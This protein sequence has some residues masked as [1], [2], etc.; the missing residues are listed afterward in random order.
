MKEQNHDKKSFPV[1]PAVFAGLLLAVSAVYAGGFLYYQSHFLPGTQI[2]GI[3]VSGMT[4]EELGEQIRDYL[5]CIAE[6]KADGSVLEEDIQGK[7][8]GLGYV[9]EEPIREILR[10]QNRYQWFLP[11]TENHRTEGLI[12]WD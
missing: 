2:D 5:L 6:R 8:I 11:Q 9:S 3:D 10:E 7:E 4:T 1:L 12:A